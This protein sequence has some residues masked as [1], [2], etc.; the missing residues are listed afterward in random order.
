[1]LDLGD[2]K[3]A[4]RLDGD[5][6]AA[7]RR[8][9]RLVLQLLLGLLH[10]SLELLDLLEHLVHVHEASRLPLVARSAADYGQA[11]IIANGVDSA[12]SGPI[13]SR[14][15]FGHDLTRRRSLEGLLPA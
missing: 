14:S 13:G 4:R 2:L 7:G 11:T 9:D 12:M 8:F 1:D 10:L 6:P 15:A 5:H 3:V